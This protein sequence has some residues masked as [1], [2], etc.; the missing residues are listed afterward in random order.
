MFRFWN[1]G[2]PNDDH[3]NE[4]CVEI[5]S[6]SSTLNNWNDLPCSMREKGFVR[7]KVHPVLFHFCLY[8]LMELFL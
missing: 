2:E 5:M 1:E 3:G 6:F 8:Y 7:N 4:D